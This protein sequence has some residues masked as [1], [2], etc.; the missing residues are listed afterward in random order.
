MIAAPGNE[1]GRFFS[2]TETLSVYLTISLSIFKVQV[3]FC[4]APTPHT[5][6]LSDS[7]Q[8]PPARSRGQRFHVLSLSFCT[9]RREISALDNQ[10]PWQPA[11]N[12][13]CNGHTLKSTHL[14]SYFQQSV[15]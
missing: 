2:L 8:K 14:L 6:T 1:L 12:T 4:V 10:V 7:E 13:Q 9:C 5:D 3:C 15:I 11:E